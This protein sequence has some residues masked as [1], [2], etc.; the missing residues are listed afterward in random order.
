MKERGSG[1]QTERDSKMST[2]TKETLTT[3][4]MNGWSHLRA[5]WTRLGECLMV[6]L[7]GNTEQT[8]QSL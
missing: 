3:Q 6:V 1:M 4:G 7:Q 8:A 2:L 5:T